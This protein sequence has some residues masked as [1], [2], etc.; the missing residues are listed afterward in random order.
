MAIWVAA[1]L[2]ITAVALFVAAPLSD[3]DSIASRSASVAGLERLEH[4]RALAVQALRELEFDYAMGK[5]GADDYRVLQRK[6][7]VRALTAMGVQ[8]T[9]SKPALLE[10]APAA[11]SRS[12][13][14]TRSIMMNFCS[15][16]GAR[17]AQ[18]QNACPSC[19]KARTAQRP[20]K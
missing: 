20:A 13:V 17:F 7:E 12:Y 8:E 1:I 19:G 2:L 10:G 6:L 4:E 3:D 18:S 15:E 11:S 14:T 16:C 9:A 5:L